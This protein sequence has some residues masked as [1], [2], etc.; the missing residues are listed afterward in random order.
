L[1][2]NKNH[3]LNVL[4][5][6]ERTIAIFERKQRHEQFERNDDAIAKEE[7]FETRDALHCDRKRGS[8]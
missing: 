6:M 5:K 7:V 3:H 8:F 4:G 1:K 2:G